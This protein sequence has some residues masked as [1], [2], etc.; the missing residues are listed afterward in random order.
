MTIIGQMKVPPWVEINCRSTARNMWCMPV[1]TSGAYSRPKMAPPTIGARSNSMTSP[2][3]MKMPMWR[4]TGPI[5][6]SANTPVTTMVVIGT[7]SN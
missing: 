3:V 2:S 4:V 7:T 1:I 5:T 6:A